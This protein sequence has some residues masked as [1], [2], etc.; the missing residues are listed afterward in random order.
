[1]P[2]PGLAVTV[3]RLPLRDADRPPGEIVS[4]AYSAD[5]K[6]IAS[7]SA[8]GLVRARTEL[9][10]GSARRVALSPDGDVVAVAS[11][12]A[13]RLSPGPTIRHVGEVADIAFGGPHRLA[14]GATDGARVSRVP[15]RPTATTCWSIQLQN[16]SRPSCHL[17][18][19]GIPRPP[20]NTVGS[21]ITS[22]RLVDPVRPLHERRPAG[23]TTPL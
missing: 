15:S 12:D 5:G 21:R 4:V 1:V 11:G 8:D 13:V 3:R 14:G 19:S 22:P 7:A 6:T 20:S 10:L 23:S 18:D 17:G 2:R 9:R 16:H